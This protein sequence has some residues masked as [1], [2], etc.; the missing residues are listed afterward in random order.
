MVRLSARVAGYLGSLLILTSAYAAAYYWGMATLEGE[1][2]T[3]YQAL[4]V[5]IHSMTTTGYGQ[6]APWETLEMTALV[7][8][9]QLTGITYIFVAVPLFVVPWL[10]TLVRPTPPEHV[11]ELEDHVIIAGYTPL[12]A[13]LVDELDSGGTE[14]VIL[15]PDGERA[16]SLHDDGLVVLHGDPATDDSLEDAQIGDALAV[17]VDESEIDHISTVIELADRDDRPRVL[18][19]VADPSRARYF[20]YAGADE[21]I[22]PKHRL[23]KALGDKVRPVV[24]GDIESDGEIELDGNLHLAEYPVE[25]DSRLYDESL[26]TFRRVESGGATVLGAWVRGNFLRTLP[27]NVHADE[28]T[29]LLAVGTADD[30]ERVAEVTGSPGSDYRPMREPVLVVGTG[31]V[32]SSVIGNLER[33]DIET[34]VLDRQDGDLVDVTGDVTTEEGLGAANV[35]DAGTLVLALDDDES[36]LLATLVARELNPDLEILAAADIEENVSRLQAAGADYALGLPNVAGRL[37]VLRI[38]E[39]EAMT[40]GDRILFRRLDVPEPFDDGLNRAAIRNRTG[41]SV[42]ALERGGDLFTDIDGRALE[43]SD[44][45]VVAGTESELSQFRAVYGLESR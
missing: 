17:V 41:C 35:T 29:T 39:R 23:G 10:Q 14:Y 30:L 2:R 11:N 9:I 22:S 43:G 8:L 42:V 15:E 38:F 26:A 34:V 28:N 18:A 7:V 45:L 36:A 1:P 12:C 32:G 21:V 25:A 31:T 6:D 37:L 27:T 33:A 20:R 3:W 13:S 44:R 4:E 40:F 19:L 16:Q 5:V 24:G